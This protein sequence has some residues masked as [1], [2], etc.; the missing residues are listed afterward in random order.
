VCESEKKGKG[1]KRGGGAV[2]VRTLKGFVL[3]FS[4]NLIEGIKY[5]NDQW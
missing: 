3:L 4:F 1:K 2:H 5:P